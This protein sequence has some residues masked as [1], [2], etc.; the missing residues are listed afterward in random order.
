M[1]FLTIVL[2][3]RPHSFNFDTTPL[4]TM[5]Q[6]P[7]AHGDGAAHVHHV[8]EVDSTAVV[9]DGKHSLTSRYMLRIY[10]VMLVGYLVSTIQGYGKSSPGCPFPARPMLTYEQT[11]RSW[12]PSTPCPPTTRASG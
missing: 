9:V 2:F 1:P 11:V 10:F 5:D 4:C 12:G 7:K 6:T 3:T 8:A